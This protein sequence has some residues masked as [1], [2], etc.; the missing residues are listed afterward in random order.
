MASK[1]RAS[2]APQDCPTDQAATH[3]ERRWSRT[4]AEVNFQFGTYSTGNFDRIYCVCDEAGEE[5]DAE[6]HINLTMNL[7]HLI[8]CGNFPDD[9]RILESGFLACDCNDKECALTKCASSMDAHN[10]VVLLRTYED[11]D[12]NPWFLILNVC[13]SKGP[14]DANKVYHVEL[15]YAAG[16]GTWSDFHLPPPFQIEDLSALIYGNC[17]DAMLPRVSKKRKGPSDERPRPRTDTELMIRRICAKKTTWILE[18][19]PFAQLIEMEDTKRRVGYGRCDVILSV[20]ERLIPLFDL[21]RPYGSQLVWIC[22]DIQSPSLSSTDDQL[23]A[24]VRALITSASDDGTSR[25][26]SEVG[27]LKFVKSYLFPDGADSGLPKACMW[28]EMSLQHLW[29]DGRNARD[30]GEMIFANDQTNQ[31]ERVLAFLLCN[32]LEKFRLCDDVELGGL[33][34]ISTTWMQ[35]HPVVISAKS[36]GHRGRG[37]KRKKS[38]EAADTA[39]VTGA[40]ADTV[41]V[42]AI[43]AATA[44]A[45]AAAAAAAIAAAVTAAAGGSDHADQGE[46][47]S[48]TGATGRGKGPDVPSGGVKDGEELEEDEKRDT[49]DRGEAGEEGAVGKEGKVILSG[50][51]IQCMTDDKQRPAGPPPLGA[52]CACGRKPHDCTCV[53]DA[54]EWVREILMNSSGD[55]AFRTD[56]RISDLV[57]AV[58]SAVIQFPD[59]CFDFEKLRFWNTGEGRMAVFQYPRGCCVNLV[60]ASRGICCGNCENAKFMLAAGRLILQRILLVR[61]RV[62]EK[63][64]EPTPEE[65]RTNVRE[66]LDRI[67]TDERRAVAASVK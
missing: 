67:S 16:F 44:A 53:D 17:K 32:T 46:K 23:Q 31:A 64:F 41:A 22:L 54:A 39:P 45:A 59:M 12:A 1:K 2:E 20:L 6:A 35:T 61:G 29:W 37:T 21:S 14:V 42:A 24:V 49:R 4:V 3:D 66:V 26:R 11:K 40:S 60:N 63:H 18:L 58:R 34:Q 5:H 9:A 57:V 56:V 38:H 52:R 36:D 47:G 30:E 48:G 10:K 55:S 33:K 27:I 28:I 13:G 65:L 51:R 19:E 7:R 8:D 25:R 62:V 15:S 43:A 50:N